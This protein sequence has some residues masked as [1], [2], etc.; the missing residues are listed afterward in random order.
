MSQESSFFRTAVLFD[1][2]DIRLIV[3]NIGNHTTFPLLIDTM[4]LFLKHL[5]IKKVHFIGINFGG[6]VALQIQNS[7]NI[8]FDIESMILINAFTTNT[9]YLHPESTAAKLF[10][11]IATRTKLEKELEAD[12]LFTEPVTESLKFIRKDINSL[13]RREAK[14]RVTLRQS[15]TSRIV[16]HVPDEAVMSIETMDRKIVLPDI[17]SETFPDVKLA[18]MKNGG[19]FP[20][21]EAPDDLY[22]YLLCHIRQHWKSFQ[23]GQDD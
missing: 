23:I 4:N 8:L 9:Y 10:T 11:A 22:P 2:L 20:H 5:H 21:L 6:F 3:L 18:M 14:C 17:V 13:D 7:R 1:E 16:L 19:D 12:G 15:L